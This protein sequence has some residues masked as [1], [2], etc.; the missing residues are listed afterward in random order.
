MKC[1]NCGNEILEGEKFCG[2]C[3]NKIDT[4]RKRFN[5]KL[6]IGMVLIVI[7]IVGICFYQTNY[8]ETNINVATGNQEKNNKKE[9]DILDVVDQDNQ[10]LKISASEL[11]SEIIKANDNKFPDYPYTKK[12]LESQ[13][14]YNVYSIRKFK[15]S[16]NISS[17]SISYCRK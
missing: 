9:K 14:N 13:G 5:T 11:I 8:K 3:G 2:K 6:I 10:E 17:I 4:N 7:G 15:Y 1:K 16:W 12:I